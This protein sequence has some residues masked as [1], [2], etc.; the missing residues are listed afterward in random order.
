MRAV[1]LQVTVAGRSRLAGVR[2]F[3]LRLPRGTAISLIVRD[4]VAEVPKGTTVIRTGDKLLVVT[5]T[6][7]RAQT[8]QRLREVSDGGR[9]A[10]W[11]RRSTPPTER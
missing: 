5:P 7:L 1:L 6:N 8:Q 3:E 4:G 10:G 11:S 9:L 2:V